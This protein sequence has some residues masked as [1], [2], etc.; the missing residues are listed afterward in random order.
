M[1]TAEYLAS[2]RKQLKQQFTS[3]ANIC[4]DDD[5]NDIMDTQKTSCKTSGPPESKT[6]AF[7]SQ[8]FDEDESTFREEQRSK[9]QNDRHH[10]PTEI[11]VQDT[12]GKLPLMIPRNEARDHPAASLLDDYATNGCP[13][14]C[15]KA[16]TRDQLLAMMQ[17]GNHKSAYAKDAITQLRAETINKV[18]HGYA[19]VVKWGDIMSNIPKNLK[20]NP[21]AMI[22]HKSKKY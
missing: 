16:W 22:P 6:V 1:D 14:D 9:I 19:R 2:A 12:I 15:G 5:S 18:K 7:V 17:R 21:I 20:I 11:P 8:D 10:F 13:V 3:T 4:S